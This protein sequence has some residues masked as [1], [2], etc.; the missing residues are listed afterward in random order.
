MYLNS[1]IDIMEENSIRKDSIDWHR[2]RE[3]SMKKTKQIKSIKDSYPIIEDIL[4]KI[5]DNHSFLLT[6][7]LEEKMGGRFKNLPV[8]ESKIIASNIA[9]IKIPA[10]FGKDSL[11]NKF[12]S[13]IQS[14]IKKLDKSEIKGWIVD[15][16]EN[17][18]GN[19][20]PMYLGLSP[21]LGEGVS[22]YFLDSNNKYLKWSCS[23][24]AVYEED[25]KMLEISNSYIL[26]SSKNK[27]AVL[28]GKSTASSGEAIALAFK[29]KDNVLFFGKP[30][31][32]LTTGNTIFELEDGAKLVLTTSVFVDRLKNIYGG[33][34]KPDKFTDEPLY[35]A[36]Y[37]I[38]Y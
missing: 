29:G 22:G 31:Y 13:L 5:G 20:W 33:E 19:M 9:Y 7:S 6:K 14:K 32:G 37:W 34:I 28:I 10:F 15:L 17:S 3:L 36:I 30:T 1:A 35:E 38:K 18:G 21:L 8:V 25:N 4:K 12:A 27:I 24:N 16:R 23:N 26:K 2:V 11:S